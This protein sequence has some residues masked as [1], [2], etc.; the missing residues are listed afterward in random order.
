[1]ICDGLGLHVVALRCAR[2]ESGGSLGGNNRDLPAGVWGWPLEKLANQ[3]SGSNASF[4]CGAVKPPATSIFPLPGCLSNILYIESSDLAPVNH[5]EEAEGE[6]FSSSL[7]LQT[8]SYNAS[9]QPQDHQ[10][11]LFR[12]LR[13]RHDPSDAFISQ[14]PLFVNQRMLIGQ[15]Y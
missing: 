1:M 14:D 2:L 4:R 13:S 8:R 15:W 3:V 10:F 11:H 5:R 12:N 6:S 7:S 9:S